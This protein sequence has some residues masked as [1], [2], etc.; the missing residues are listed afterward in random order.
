MSTT[1]LSSP[2]TTYVNDSDFVVSTLTEQTPEGDV[3]DVVTDTGAGDAHGTDGSVSPL[4]PRVTFFPS[5]HTY[6]RTS[7]VGDPFPS[8]TFLGQMMVPKSSADRRA[9]YQEETKNIK[10]ASTTRA[11]TVIGA[12]ECTDTM[13]CPTTFSGQSAPH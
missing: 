10:G 11:P 3:A 9:R 13:P 2:L 8:V 5:S 6:L 7:G 12:M 4:D 1:F